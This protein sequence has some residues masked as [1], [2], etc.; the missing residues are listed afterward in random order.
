MASGLPPGGFP[1]RMGCR[2]ILLPT[3]SRYS[4][5]DVSATSRSPSS[6]TRIMRT[7]P[8]WFRPT[9]AC[10]AHK[11]VEWQRYQGGIGAEHPDRPPAQ[12]SDA[13]HSAADLIGCSAPY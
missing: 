4:A 10:A 7:A 2:P 3:A 5:H 6:A 12:T 13:Q 1:G 8:G 9:Y 11:G